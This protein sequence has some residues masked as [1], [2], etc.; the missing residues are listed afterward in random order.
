MT[1]ARKAWRG[2]AWGALAVRCSTQ[3][4]PTPQICCLQN[5]RARRQGQ[6]APAAKRELA[7]FNNETCECE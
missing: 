6:L 1:E 3:P 4:Y 7:D 5:A 2:V